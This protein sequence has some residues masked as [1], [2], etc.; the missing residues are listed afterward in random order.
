MVGYLPDNIVDMHLVNV[1]RKYI[2]MIEG[3]YAREV[4]LHTITFSQVRSVKRCSPSD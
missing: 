2:K 3:I 4:Y 1:I